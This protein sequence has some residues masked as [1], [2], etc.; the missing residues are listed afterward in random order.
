MRRGY[1]RVRGNSRPPQR[2]DSVHYSD[3]QEQDP[4]VCDIFYQSMVQQCYTAFMEES[5]ENVHTAST[6]DKTGLWLLKYEDHSTHWIWKLAVERDVALFP[7]RLLNDSNRLRLFVKVAQL[8]MVC[9]S[10]WHKCMVKSYYRV[11]KERCCRIFPLTFWT[12]QYKNHF[13]STFTCIYLPEFI[14]GKR[15]YR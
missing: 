6:A 12:R 7:R 3:W 4:D 15:I 5:F 14:L 11:N 2:Q 8:S 13:F 10:I 1:G 9:V